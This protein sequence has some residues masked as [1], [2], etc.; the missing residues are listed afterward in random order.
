MNMVEGNEDPTQMTK[1]SKS[2][3]QDL[4]MANAY[5]FAR[6]G[7]PFDLAQAQSDYKYA[8]AGGTQNTLKL[9]QS[10]TGDNKNNSGTFKQ[11]EDRFNDLGNT[12][13]PKV[14]NIFNWLSTNAG[15]PGIPA[16]D[17]TLLGVA[18][19]YGK[20]LGGGVA[21]DSS[22]NEAKE[23]INKAFSDQ[24]GKAALNAIRGTLA[25]RQNAMV[26]DNRYLAKQYGKMD[27]P[28]QPGQTQTQ[29]QTQAPDKQKIIQSIT[30][31]GGGHPVDVK[32]G[33]NGSM[34]VW[35]GKAGDAWINPATGQAVK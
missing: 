32:F 7:K 23:I 5:S 1:R 24:Q 25:N 27:Q 8:T 29:N 28:G 16:F 31:P 17:A 13:I 21:T 34:I 2:Y 10:L 22:R 4:K 12:Q 20:I 18:D 14:N 33:P 3:N 15:R 19:E 9:L 11:L 6:Y 30:L 26:G 35:S